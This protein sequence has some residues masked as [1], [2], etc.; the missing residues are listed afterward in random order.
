MHEDSPWRDITLF[1]VVLMI[2]GCLV[3]WGVLIAV[4]RLISAN[5]GPGNGGPNDQPNRVERLRTD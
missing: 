2:T 4:D 1:V 3:M 5:L